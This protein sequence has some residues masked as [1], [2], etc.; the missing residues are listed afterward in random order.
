MS[1][2]RRA[3]SMVCLVLAV[4]CLCG[5]LTAPAMGE[6]ATPLRI[7]YTAAGFDFV[8]TAAWVARPESGTAWGRAGS[9]TRRRDDFPAAPP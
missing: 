3:W 9:S 8:V 1:R 5:F 2:Y 6:G 4:A 7:V